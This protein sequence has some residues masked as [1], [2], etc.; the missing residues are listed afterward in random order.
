[1]GMRFRK[2]FRL[3][4]G[5]RINLSKSG[6]STTIGKRGA[7]VNIGPKKSSVTVGMPGTGL[8]F[9]SHSKNSQVQPTGPRSQSSSLVSAPV[10]HFVEHEIHSGDGSDNEHY[11]SAP[12]ETVY[13]IA[14][15]LASILISGAE[16]KEVEARIAGLLPERLPNGLSS[17][18]MANQLMTYAMGRDGTAYQ[19]TAAVRRAIAKAGFK[20]IELV[21]DA[22]SSVRASLKARSN[23]PVDIKQPVEWYR[24][25]GE[26]KHREFEAPSIRAAIPPDVLKGLHATQVEVGRQRLNNP[27]LL[28]PS[29][30]PFMNW[31][32]VGVAKL[33]AFIFAAVAS[34]M[35]FL[36][37]VS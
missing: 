3:M 8:S 2:S 28:K 16:A 24:D 32:I 22:V 31:L 13:R 9:T 29:R 4:S 36:A 15:L 5:V 33:I 11:T 34:L 1:M 19:G 23:A 26:L 12:H 37:I 25:G 35:I 30:A 17:P 20:H 14:A 10:T 21:G 27:E 18:Q 7:S 6:L